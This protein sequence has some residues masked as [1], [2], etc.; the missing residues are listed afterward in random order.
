MLYFQIWLASCHVWVISSINKRAAM[1][2]WNEMYWE[3]YMSGQINIQTVISFISVGQNGI[4]I[5]WNNGQ[6][7][8]I[9]KQLM[10]GIMSFLWKWHNTVILLTGY[11]Q[12]WQMPSVSHSEFI[13]APPVQQIWLLSLMWMKAVCFCKFTN[14]TTRWTPSGK[15]NF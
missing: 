2:H 10:T 6:N 5:T 7:V 8:K 13:R 1:C 15:K 9:V 11:N 12:V 14:E 3:T 4:E